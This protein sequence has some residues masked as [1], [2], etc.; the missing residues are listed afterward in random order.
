MDYATR[1][2]TKIRL[3]IQQQMAEARAVG[4]SRMHPDHLLMQGWVIDINN[5]LR[6]IK[7]QGTNAKFNGRKTTTRAR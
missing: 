6:A 2:L 4:M 5:A 3:E 1:K 7:L